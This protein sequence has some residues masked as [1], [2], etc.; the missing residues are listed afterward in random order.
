MIG[1]F[2]S[3]R[4][5]DT[6]F[7]WA[8]WKEVVL[9]DLFDNDALRIL[10]TVVSIRREPNDRTLQ[11]WTQSFKHLKKLASKYK[12]D[13][14]GPIWHY[15]FMGQVTLA[16]RLKGKFTSYKTTEERE[17]FSIVK[18]EKE[19]RLVAQ[20]ELPYFKPER[21]VTANQTKL[22]VVS[23]PATERQKEAKI[24]KDK[25][26]GKQQV[27]IRKE[28]RDPMPTEAKQGYI[29]CHDCGYLHKQGEHSEEGRKKYRAR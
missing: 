16:K 26:Q 20:E 14:P 17:E 8:R 18:F 13:L 29:N 15:Y 24:T 7:T 3:D 11:K 6:T 19:L 10:E 9:V 1:T 25:A 12:V 28:K 4:E 5:S 2:N 21:L 23:R 22:L 27:R